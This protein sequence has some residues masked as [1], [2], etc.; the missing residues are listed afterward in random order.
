[1]GVSQLTGRVLGE[2]QPAGLDRAVSEPGD[3]VSHHRVAEGCGMSWLD[4]TAG[5]QLDELRDLLGLWDAK[6]R[7]S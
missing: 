1:V 2:K 4:R 3:P 5:D 7:P 6:G